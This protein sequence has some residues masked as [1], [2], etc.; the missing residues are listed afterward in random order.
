[1][2]KFVPLYG[3]VD[4]IPANSSKPIIE[5]KV[6]SGYVAE[7]FAIGVIPD[8][9]PATGASYLDGVSV[10][11]SDQEGV[12]GSVFQHSNISANHDGKNAAPYG[13]AASRQPMLVIDRPLTFGNLT[14]K[15]A[16]GK[17]IQLVGRASG[18]ATGKV[19]AR[20]FIYLLDKN[21]VMNIWGISL[22]DFA[23]LAGG[24]NQSKPVLPYF[25]YY[26]NKATSGTGD[27][28][29]L[30]SIKVEPYEEIQLFQCG[31]HPHDN[32][33]LL[34]FYDDRL[35]KYFP[36]RNPYYWRITA[37]ENMLPFGDD[38]DYQ[39][40]L[41]LPDDIVNHIW[42]ETNLDIQIQDNNAVIPEGGVRVQ[43][44][45][46]YRSKGGGT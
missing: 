11:Y 13:N 25:E 20:A 27:W 32:S 41:P 28:E 1:M 14:Y 30:A 31:V 35:N 29:N 4:S 8:L 22:D 46:I 3:E 45:G 6:P 15:F 16:T 18:T 21:D 34:R 7:L 44:V 36:D 10:A 23:S 26:D 2:P 24:H 33:K 5:Y 38:E 12:V 9:D 40:R 42:T 39:G 17:I 43:L 19:R 37:T